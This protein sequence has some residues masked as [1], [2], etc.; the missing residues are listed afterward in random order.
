LATVTYDHVSK[1]FNGMVAVADLDLRIGDGEF[2][3]LVGPSGCGK[4]TALRLIAGLE[5]VTSGNLYIG[6]RRVNEV[7]SR[8]RDVAMVFQN[9]ALYP[10]MSVHENL[11]F[12]LTNRRVPKAEIQSRVKRAA[13]ML[14]IQTLLERKPRE[15]SGGQRQRVALGRAI[16]REPQVFLMDEPLSNLDAQLR[17]QTRAELVR[18][19]RRLATTTIYV[20]HDQVEAMTM[21]QRIAVMRDGVLQQI[22]TPEGLY[23]RPANTFVA[24]FIGSPSMNFF[25]G[26]LGADGDRIMVLG[27]GL[28]LPLPSETAGGLGSFVGR[29]ILFGIRPEHIIDPRQAATSNTAVAR[30][31]VSVVE[32]LG[33][34]VFVYLEADGQ[35]FVARLDP[36]YTPRPGDTIDVAFATDRIHL[37]DPESEIALL[38]P[39]PDAPRPITADPPPLFQS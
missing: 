20:T 23:T 36:R 8:D 14:G 32:R 4:S 6:D 22:D 13:E 16:V 29:R 18:L 27:A 21:G 24:G 5:Q 35:E 26:E 33:A 25:A 37:F 38:R 2:I 10:H 30:A 19:H 15:L 17:V 28:R 34:E 7:A 9:Y 11:A 1:H 39:E 3:V 31:Q 12:G